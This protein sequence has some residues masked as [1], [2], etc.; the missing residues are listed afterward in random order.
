MRHLHSGRKFGIDSS[1]RDAMFRNLVTSLMEH[2]EIRTT[3]AKAKELRRVAERVITYA[4]KVPNASLAGLEGAELTEAKAKRVHAVR[5]ARRYIT[6]R[7]VLQKVFSEYSDRYA[8][9]PGGYTRILKLGRRPGDNAPMALIQLVTEPCEPK[10]KRSA[11]VP[12]E[13]ATAE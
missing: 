11:E 8:T 13:T 2:G 5:L 4:K 7:D 12:A 1:H 9:R 3:E 10:A 6:N